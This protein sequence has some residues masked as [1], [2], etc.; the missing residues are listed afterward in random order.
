[1]AICLCTAAYGCLS[2]Y[3]LQRIRAEQLSARR[4]Q[5]AQA[6]RQQRELDGKR[7]I[8]EQ[9]AAFTQRAKDSGLEA[10]AW[11]RYA[12][13]VQAP[14]AYEAASEIISQCGDSSKAYFWPIT[15]E[16]SVPDTKAATAVPARQRTAD[17]A[18][19][20]LSVKGQFVAKK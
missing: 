11:T 5:L 6:H 7:S 2:A 13:N 9:A 16:V 15:L 8:L 4:T 1:M 19:V 17:S 12:V 20:Y 18:D 3:G 14:L 10:G